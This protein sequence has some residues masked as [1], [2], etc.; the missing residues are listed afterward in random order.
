MPDKTKDGKVQTVSLELLG[1]SCRCML[2]FS[3][4]KAY[5][6]G[7]YVDT[8]QA[9]STR[10]AFLQQP[11]LFDPVVP[12]ISTE[13]QQQDRANRGGGRGQDTFDRLVLLSSRFPK[14][15]RIVFA[16][17]IDAGHIKH[18]YEKWLNQR[19]CILNDRMS[20]PEQQRLINS[21]LHI[22]KDQKFQ[23]GTEMIFTWS[24]DNCLSVLVNGQLQS[25]FHDPWLCWAIFDIYAGLN[26]VSTNIRDSF[27]Q[28]WNE[29]FPMATD[30]LFLKS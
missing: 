21:F 15:L 27:K 19:S 14:A 23:E 1:L 9:E 2:N 17:S 10:F 22:F 11:E 12:I 28:G 26:P 29:R 16:K 6:I 5:A 18:G 30:S 20:P 24:T 4:W 25:Q 7:L 3:L 8:S 13:Q